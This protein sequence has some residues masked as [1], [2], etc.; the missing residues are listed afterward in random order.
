MKKIL[1]TLALGLGLLTANA[2]INWCDSVSY[3]IGS[4][5]STFNVSIEIDAIP[6]WDDASIIWSVYNTSQCYSDT[7]PTAHFQMIQPTD[8]IKVCYD[9]YLYTTVDTILCQA[10]DSLNMY[11]HDN[12]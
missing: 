3:I 10:C 9:L 6:V 4:P 1:L 7:N 2:Q 5:D 8:T 11:H 12:R